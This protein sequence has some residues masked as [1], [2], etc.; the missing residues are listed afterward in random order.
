MMK[1]EAN[2]AMTIAAILAFVNAIPGDV[3]EGNDGQ[4]QTLTAKNTPLF[5]QGMT[6]L[7]LVSLRRYPP[8]TLDPVL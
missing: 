5:Q 2:Q 1:V 6:L 3:G 8:K 7:P 4:S